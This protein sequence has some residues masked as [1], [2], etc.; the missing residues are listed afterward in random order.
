M[1]A[2]AAD[3]AA[4]GRSEVTDSIVERILY[5]LPD[6][7]IDRAAIAQVLKDL[8]LGAAAGREL[9]AYLEVHPDSLTSGRSDGPPAGCVCSSNW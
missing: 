5:E 9:H 7:A 8:K 6:G 3:S 2:T 1:L 4:R